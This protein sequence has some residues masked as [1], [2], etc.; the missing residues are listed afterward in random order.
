VKKSIS[1]LAALTIALAT[2]FIAAPVQPALAERSCPKQTADSISQIRQVPVVYVHGWTANG[3]DAER[4]TVP[5][6]Q[7]ALGDRYQVFAFDYVWA[8]TTWGAEEKISGCLAQF[9]EHLS[10]ANK[11]AQGAGQVAIVAHSMGGLVSRA[12]TTYLSQDGRSE[13]LAGIVTVG[14]PHQGT[15]FYGGLATFQENISR[16]NPTFHGSPTSKWNKIATPPND[17]P[18]SKCLAFPHPAPCAPVPYVQPGQKIA[19]V[20]GQV[21]VTV[22]FFGLKLRDAAVI[23]A[24][25][26][27]VPT[28]SALGYPGS[29]TGSSPRGSYLGEK[30]VVCERTTSQLNAMSLQLGFFDIANVNSYLDEEASGRAG[31]GMSSWAYA[32]NFIGSPCNHGALPTTTEAIGD[33]AAFIRDMHVGEFG[34]TQSFTGQT[35]DSQFAGPANQIQFSF[36]YRGEWAVASKYTGHQFEVTDENG[37]VLAILSFP[38]DFSAAPP[39]SMPTRLVQEPMNATASLQPSTQPCTTCNLQVQSFA[40]DSREAKTADGQPAMQ[41]WSKPVAAI[42]RLGA[43]STPPATLTGLGG[44]SAH[45]LKTPLGNTAA[46]D[47]SSVRYFDTLDEAEAWLKSPD[48]KLVARMLLSLR[49][50]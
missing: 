14:T 5:L 27:I 41:G 43:S 8:N 46:A 7:E 33:A 6:L 45:L 23:D 40:I 19:S 28:A 13:A 31:I 18:A 47:W 21:N 12:A 22:T 49:F 35:P 2:L 10:D 17:S 50:S 39:A 26:S 42:T 30:R 29:F 32:L 34:L 15:A 25:D 38:L 1:G 36:K 37:N 11:A 20:A 44:P 48:H 16:I 9:V 4:D 3:A 24:G